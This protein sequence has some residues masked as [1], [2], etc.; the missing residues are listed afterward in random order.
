MK[1]LLIELHVETD[2]EL[3][4]VL[5]ELERSSLVELDRNFRPVRISRRRTERE[6]ASAPDTFTVRGRAAEESI[7]RLAG[8]PF[9]YRVWNDTPIDHFGICNS[10]KKG[11]LDKVAKCIGAKQLWDKG[12]SGDGVVI[13]IVDGGV[14]KSKFPVIGGSRS[15]WGTVVEWDEH[16]HMTA[17]DALG[18]APQASIYD[19]RVSGPD[20]PAVISNALQAY[21]WAIQQFDI[22]GT[23]HIL[24]NSWGI[25]QKA[26]DPDY[27]TNPNHPF[28]LKMEEALDRGIKVL[29]SAGNCG[30]TCPSQSCKG[31][32]GGGSSIWGAGGHEEVMCV[33]AV[34][35]NN[36]RLRYSSQGPAA[37]HAAKPDFCGYSSFKGYFKKDSGTSASCPVIAGAVAV[38]LSYDPTLSQP[39]IKD[40]LQRTAK[41]IKGL[42]FDHDTGH[43]VVRLDAAYYDLVP[44]DKPDQ[45]FRDRLCDRVYHGERR[46]VKEE[47]EGYLACAQTRDDGYLDCAEERDEGYL[48]C[49][50][51][52]DDGYNACCTWWPCSWGCKALVWMANVFCVV[53]TW[54]KNVVCVAWTWI[55]N[56]VCVAWTWLKA[57]VCK[58]WLWVLVR[59]T[60]T[61]CACR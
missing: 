26:W 48:A 28:T 37:L 57:R 22:D 58:L 38:L 49:T 52:R 8:L 33:A 9:V 16:G 36:R 23:P 17:T 46:C 53:W 56:L 32:T 31:D 40:L 11:T 21:D 5:A 18:V 43:G 24:S 1:N 14:D 34:K 6:P 2:Q 61:N 12:Y 35:L 10:S 7:A 59:V 29:F 51:T 25:Y 41:D 50:E 45:D 4:S 42:G 27:A 54:I 39:Q 15:D 3:D 60:L 47:V 55:K 13:G 30:E 19:L 44:G 20:T